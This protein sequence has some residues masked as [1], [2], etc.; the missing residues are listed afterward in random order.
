MVVW[1]TLVW[2]LPWCVKIGDRIWNPRT[3]PVGRRLAKWAVPLNVFLIAL[4]AG[5]FVGFVAAAAM[6]SN[7]GC[8]IFRS[9]P[10]AAA[11]C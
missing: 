9:S 1:L 5:V 7:S 8:S 11:A 2:Q 4:C 10:L 3:V 6:V